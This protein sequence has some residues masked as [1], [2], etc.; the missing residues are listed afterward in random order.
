MRLFV[1]ISL[2]ERR[3]CPI[4]TIPITNYIFI[5]DPLLVGLRIL[6]GQQTQVEQG[7][8]MTRPFMTK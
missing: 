8:K 3:K 5:L 6:S 7:I 2:G 1:Q 4:Y